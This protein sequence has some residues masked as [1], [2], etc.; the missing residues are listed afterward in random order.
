MKKIFKVLSSL[1]VAVVLV[2]ACNV[3]NVKAI[4]TPVGQ[5]E[6]SFSQS[7]FVDKEISGTATSVDIQIARSN[8]SA[9]LSV[10]L[11]T[12]LPA[13]IGVPTSVTF[14]SGEYTAIV[15]LDVS[16]MVVGTVYKG[17]I[18]VGDTTL[19]NKSV[20]VPEVSLTLSKVYTWVSL[21]KGQ[22]YDLLVLSQENSLGIREVEILKADGFDRW[23]IIE[24][25]TVE[26]IE[27]ADW[28]ARKDYLPKYIEIY[29]YD[30]D[31]QKLLGWDDYWMTG[32]EYD[33]DIPTK[34]YFPD[35]RLNDSGKLPLNKR[36]SDDIFQLVPSYYMDGLG[37]WASKAYPCYLGLPGVD[38]EAFLTEE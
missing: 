2:S 33:K 10:P 11:T 26:A 23:R 18:E 14:A 34:A 22:W 36:L 12:T 35:G 13:E 1:A 29:E 32:I 6:V 37:G 31:G 8:A 16:A 5:N 20:S 25:Y 24:P 28:T 9:E 30:K 17:K 3:E 21:G 7:V 38:L 4:Y 19:F 15:T 27:A